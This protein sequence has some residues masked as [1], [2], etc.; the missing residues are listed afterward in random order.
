MGKGSSGAPKQKESKA[1]K[2]RTQN[3]LNR[4]KEWEKDGYRALEA[5]GLERARVDH[6]NRLQKSANADVQQA[7][8]NEQKNL[9]VAVGQGN[10]G[11][12]QYDFSSQTGG[13][14]NE[15]IIEATKSAEGLKDT[16]R[17]NMAKVGQD[18]AITSDNALSSAARRGASK[19]RAKLEGSTLR[20][21]ARTSALVSVATGAMTG[22]AL[23]NPKPK[24]DMNASQVVDPET[25]RTV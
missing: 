6:T 3:A 23:R 18:V 5:E 17:L 8:A 11:F 1:E 22:A 16:A 15:A 25:A 20:N 12:D 21:R 19:A 10:Y 9:G 14:A 7:V 4:I 24:T 13:V 2:E